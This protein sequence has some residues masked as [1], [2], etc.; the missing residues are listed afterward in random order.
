MTFLSLVNAINGA[1]TTPSAFIFLGAALILT[2]KNQFLQLRAVPRF[3]AIIKKN[4]QAEQHA[5]NHGDHAHHIRGAINPF[6][7]LFAAL[8]TT[9]GMGTIVGPSIAIIMG[10][11]GALFWLLV[12]AFFA[13]V[14]KFTEVTLALRTRRVT[15]DGTLIGGPAEYLKL[16]HPAVATWY[17]IAIAALLAGWS[18]LQTNTLASI[19]MLGGTPQW[20][21][22]LALSTIMLVV[23]IGGA[24]RVGNVASKLVPL[25]CFLYVTFGLLIIATNYQMI[26]P[27]LSLMFSN[28]LNPTAAIG[29]FA[30]ATIGAALRAGVYRSIHITEAGLGTSAIA[31]AVADAKPTDQGIMAMYSMVAD[32]SLAFLSGFLVLV[33]GVWTKVAH[34]DNTLMYR[35]FSS[36]CH[37]GFIDFGR[38]ILLISVTLFVV[39]TVIGNSFNGSQSFASLTNHRWVKLY[40]FV[41]ALGIF[42]GAFVDVPL[43]WAI[44]DVIMTFAVIPNIISLV[45]L[46]YKKSDFFKLS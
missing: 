18:A 24:E 29:G 14:T 20:I 13:S 40:L 37:F 16:V 22:G 17:G 23:L 44:M 42:F 1:L 31:H 41:A 34:F 28:I 33:T 38:I 11:P 12:Y 30:G 36:F 25:M 35:V 45:Y 26:V 19:F 6:H 8:G 5:H 7:A 3:F 15:K 9:L 10:G 27:A 21:T 46:A 2:I 4:R 32:A 43:L 39:T